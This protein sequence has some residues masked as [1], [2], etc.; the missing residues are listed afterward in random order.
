MEPTRGL[1][2]LTSRR[3]TSTVTNDSLQCS[4]FP[5]CTVAFSIRSV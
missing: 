3:R 4:L 1:E 2:P 5:G